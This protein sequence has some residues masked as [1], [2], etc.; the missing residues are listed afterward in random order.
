MLFYRYYQNFLFKPWLIQALLMNGIFFGLGMAVYFL[1]IEKPWTALTREQIKNNR[2]NTALKQE[3]QRAVLILENKKKL[4]VNYRINN[5]YLYG[6]QIDPAPSYMMAKIARWTEQTNMSVKHISVQPEKDKETGR[7]FK[8]HLT[9]LGDY[10]RLV[11]FFFLM[12]EQP[13][14][15]QVEQLKIE[16]SNQNGEDK[17]YVDV[18]FVFYHFK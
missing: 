6:S 13:F 4:G 10:H 1:S 5:R 3:K 12:S 11:Q 9:L 17:L 7:L 8:I 14:L 15:L 16:K 2:L 18:F